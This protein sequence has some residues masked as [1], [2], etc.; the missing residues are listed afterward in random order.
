MSDKIFSDDKILPKMPK[1][2][3]TLAEIADNVSY[4]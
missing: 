1:D 3:L 4:S 2:F